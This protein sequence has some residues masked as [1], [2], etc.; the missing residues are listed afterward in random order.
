MNL[1]RDISGVWHVNNCFNLAWVWLEALWCQNVTDKGN[2]MLL[3][4]CFILFSL[5]VSLTA[6]VQEATNISVMV[7]L[8]LSECVAIA[9]CHKIICNDLNSFQLML[10]PLS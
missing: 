8:P 5:E 1:R 6:A 3:Q 9:N 4:P 7:S 10:V 2:F